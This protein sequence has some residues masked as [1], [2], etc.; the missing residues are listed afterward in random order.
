MS[1]LH[2]NWGACD[3]C[4][5]INHAYTSGAKEADRLR[6][7]IGA[8]L[9]QRDELLVLVKRYAS[10]CGECG[11]NG[12]VCVDPLDAAAGGAQDFAC[13]DCADIRAALT[14]AN[15]SD[16]TTHTEDAI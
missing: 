7:Q 11:G 13:P 15:G 16:T 3:A 4:D 14:K 12:V 10:E 9:S 2:G 1:C 5:E 8:L 6:Q